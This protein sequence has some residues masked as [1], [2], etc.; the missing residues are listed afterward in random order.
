MSKLSLPDKT[1]LEA[2][3]GMSGGHVLDLTNTSLAQL[4]DDLAVDIY[5]DKYAEYGVSKAN[6]LRTLWRI[7]SDYEVAAALGT[8]ADY[9]EAKQAA[10]GFSGFREEITDDQIARIR[11]IAVELDGAPSAGMGQTTAADNVADPTRAI[12]TTEATVSKNKIQIEIHGEIYDHIGQYLVTGDYFHAVEESYKLVRGKLREI[13]GKEKAS[14]VF[15]NS[16]QNTAHY[17]AL[18][19]KATPANDAE[20]DFFRGIGYLHL[21]VQHLRNEKAHTPATSLEPNLAVHYISLAS[22]A[23]DLIT[24]YVSKETIRELEDLVLAKRQSYPTAG[25]F[26]RDFEDGKW[27][28]N[29]TLPAKL[30]SSAVR[31]VL[32]TK[33]LDEADFTRSYDHSNIVLMRLELVADELIGADLDRLLDLPTKDSYGNDQSAGMRQFLTFLRRKYPDTISQKA[34]DWLAKEQ[35]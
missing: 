20:A 22:L 15:N 31:K 24:R 28:R 8:F 26:Y 6:R 9:I 5:D 10:P 18:F 16:A 21:G 11:R 35:P 19:G 13:T 2:V 12:Y 29:L 30:Q 7:G 23:Y 3:L 34:K 33:W 25:A 14:D 1:F 32:K 4:F 27:L 17:E